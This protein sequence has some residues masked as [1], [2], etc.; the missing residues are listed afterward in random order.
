VGELWQIGQFAG[1]AAIGL[2]VATFAVFGA[3]VFEVFS[4]M[5]SRKKESTRRVLSA[6]TTRAQGVA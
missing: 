2:A 1:Y 3:F 6:S 5:T 4:L